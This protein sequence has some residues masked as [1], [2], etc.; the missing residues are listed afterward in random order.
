MKEFFQK[1]YPIFIILGVA[2]VLTTYKMRTLKKAVPEKKE[3]SESVVQIDSRRFEESLCDSCAMSSGNK[4]TCSPVLVRQIIADVDP[5]AFMNVTE[6]VITF[7]KNPS[8]KDYSD[9]D[10]IE[11]PATVIANMKDLNLFITQTEEHRNG[12]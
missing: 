1:I 12:R 4:L 8:D 10:Y 3:R 11:V 2:V 9:K 7:K 5:T 6:N